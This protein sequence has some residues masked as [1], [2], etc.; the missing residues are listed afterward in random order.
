MINVFK[1]YSIPF[2]SYFATI[3]QT[4]KIKVINAANHWITYSI[5]FI[6]LIFYIEDNTIPVK[7]RYTKNYVPKYKQNKLYC[8]MII[9]INQT[10]HKIMTTIDKWETKYTPKYSNKPIK[11]STNR[12]HYSTKNKGKTLVAMSIL[13]MASRSGKPLPRD[14]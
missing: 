9:K 13:A 2:Y 1:F 12:K 6:Y 3:W 4:T 7:Y 14:F 11:L 8:K 5:L 10:V